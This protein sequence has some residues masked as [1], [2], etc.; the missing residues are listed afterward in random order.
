MSPYFSE[1]VSVRAGHKVLLFAHHIQPLQE[2][3]NKLNRPPQQKAVYIDGS[4]NDR[5]RKGAVDAFQTD[6][7]VRLAVLSIT[8]AGV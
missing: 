2:M 6:S 5:K 7:T 4:T 8:A 3:F 1:C